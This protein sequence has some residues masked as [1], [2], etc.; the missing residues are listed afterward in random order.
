[1][2]DT[3]K[4]TI[5]MPAGLA[6]ALTA[7]LESLKVVAVETKG[8]SFN[9]SVVGV[10]SVGDGNGDPVPLPK[11]AEEV[12]QFCLDNNLVV[13]GQRFYNYYSKLNWINTK[14]KPVDNWKELIFMWD[15]EDRRKYPDRKPMKPK[16]KDSFHDDV[17][18]LERMLGRKDSENAVDDQGQSGN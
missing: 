15:E 1:M 2:N 18:R 3:I 10:S 8:N 12:I 7:L 16:D 6:T 4:L 9:C 11:D 5:E 14:G 13:D 17:S